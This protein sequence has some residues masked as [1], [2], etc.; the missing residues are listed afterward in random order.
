MCIYLAKMYR[1]PTLCQMRSRC[2]AYA[3]AQTATCSHRP[4]FHWET[5]TNTKTSYSYLFK[6]IKIK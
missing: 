5:E 4:M 3:A 1:V 2:W 6:E